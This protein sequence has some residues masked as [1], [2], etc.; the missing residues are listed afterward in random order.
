MNRFL[1][2]VAC[3][4]LLSAPAVARIDAPELPGPWSVGR[5]TETVTDPARDRQLTVDIW[6]PVDA[7]DATGTQSSYDLVFALLPSPTAL[8]GPAV[9]VAG[10]R[11]LVIF[12][13]GSFGIRFQSF[14]LMEHLASHGYIVVSPDH[15]GNTAADLVFD[16]VA[17]F[18]QIVVDRPLDVTFLIDWMLSR[19]ATPADRFDGRLH[20]QQ[21]AVIGGSFGGFTSI[22]AAGGTSETPADPRIRAIV[23]IVP[24]SDIL[25]DAELSGIS[26]PA[27]ILGGTSD[28]TTPIDPNSV[29][30]F[31][32]FNG[33]R[34]RV[35]ILDGGHQSFNN[36][37]VF[38]EVLIGVGIP[39]SLIDF[40][41]GSSEEGCSPDLIPFTEAH[42]LTKLYATAFL[43]RELQRMGGYQR[44][45][46][47]G[48][49]QS[50]NLPVIFL[51]GKN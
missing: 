28:I 8:D 34:Y 16:T 40:L 47:R 45:L 29:R 7:A 41:L 39:P 46:N 35:D 38:A 12:S 42:M 21:I 50:N 33:L 15:A 43:K 37:C 3:V 9:S 5:V 44:Y 24:A 36:I 26:I 14:F 49:A 6:Y 10:T 32:L 18:E 27:L 19:N 51:R 25:S 23:P 22:A 13:H 17:P 31:E 30:P 1:Q 20:P 11:P 48:Y 2:I 4:F